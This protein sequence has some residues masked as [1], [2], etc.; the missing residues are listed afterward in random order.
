MSLTAE[1]TMAEKRGAAKA[2]IKIDPELVRKARQV[3]AHED[4]KIQDYI[5]TLLRGPIERDL[6]RVLDRVAGQQRKK[7]KGT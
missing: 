2:T 6:D 4:V 5:D 1:R 7:K 3:C